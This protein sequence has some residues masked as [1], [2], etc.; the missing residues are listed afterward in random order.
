MKSQIGSNDKEA[1]F[2]RVKGI[3]MVGDRDEN[4]IKQSDLSTDDRLVFSLPQKLARKLAALAE[5]IEE[6]VPEVALDIEI[7]SLEAALVNI[8]E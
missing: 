5:E 8:S 4:V 7:K 2:E 6:N 3:F 1:I